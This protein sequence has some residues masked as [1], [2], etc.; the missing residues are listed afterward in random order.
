MI[1]LSKDSKYFELKSEEEQSTITISLISGFISQ[2][3]MEVCKTLDLFFKPTTTD[4][5]EMG[6]YDNGFFFVI[7][8]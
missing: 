6:A 7:S 1:R 2:E 4:K 5:F 8:N 3:F